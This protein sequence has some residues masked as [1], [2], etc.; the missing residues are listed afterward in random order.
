[1]ITKVSDVNATYFYL[2]QQ[3]QQLA[4]QRLLSIS[5]W[6]GAKSFKLEKHQN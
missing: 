1:V 6:L 4:V 3:Q 2:V 5:D